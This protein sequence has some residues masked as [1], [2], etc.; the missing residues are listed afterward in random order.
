MDK[1]GFNKA[2]VALANRNARVAFALIRGGKAFN[3]RQPEE[4]VRGL[5]RAEPSALKPGQ[6]GRL[7]APA[8]N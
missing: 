8:A 7:G 6:T 2:A 4:Q 5:P 1:K 3:P